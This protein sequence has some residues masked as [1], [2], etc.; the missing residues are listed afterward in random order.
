MLGM[1]AKFNHKAEMRESKDEMM[2]GE[3]VR[4]MARQGFPALQFWANNDFQRVKFRT[5]GDRVLAN[6]YVTL[7]RKTG[8]GALS[9]A[10][11]GS[12]ATLVVSAEVKNYVADPDDLLLMYKTDLQNLFK[13]P[14]MGGVRLNHEMNSVFATTAVV[15]DIDDYVMKGPQGTAGLTQWLVQTV[16]LLREKLAPYKK[17]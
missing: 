3:I 8:T 5:V 10:L 11:V 13:L 2:V 9:A 6:A 15:L 12:K 1:L 7:D 17:G 14:V 16:T 4:A